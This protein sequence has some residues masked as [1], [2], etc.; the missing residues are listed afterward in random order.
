MT[1]REFAAFLDDHFD[2]KL[3]KSVADEFEDHLSI[4]PDCRTYLRN[5][6]LTIDLAR[7]SANDDGAIPESVPD[8]LVEAVLEA[9]RRHS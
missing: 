5:Y 4:C 6:R 3:P 8:E 9:R 7:D 1:C 2:G